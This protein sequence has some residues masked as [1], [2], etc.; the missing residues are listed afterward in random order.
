MA[1][2]EH[3]CR[4]VAPNMA[5]VGPTMIPLKLD[6]PRSQIPVGG[7]HGGRCPATTL[8]HSLRPIT[9]A[10]HSGAECSQ[11]ILVVYCANRETSQRYGIWCQPK[12]RG[13]AAV[14]FHS[15]EHRRSSA[16]RSLGVV[17]TLR[18]ARQSCAMTTLRWA[19]GAP[20]SH[21]DAAQESH[22]HAWP[23]GQ[24]QRNLLTV[25]GTCKGPRRYLASN[26]TPP[27]NCADLIRE[28]RWTNPIS[29]ATRLTR[30]RRSRAFSK[31]ATS[32][33]AL[34]TSTGQLSPL[35]SPHSGGR[36][37]IP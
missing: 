21:G 7:T 28:P 1:A 15:T 27:T 16:T 32:S 5:S 19:R 30:R 34:M 2:C 23:K 31:A 11:L 4:Y 10:T 20:Q 3:P 25:W 24:S 26:I 35:H 29:R 33:A 14:I 17:Q 8:E 18:P 37:G 22:M 9:P 13:G 6:L 12:R 36:Y